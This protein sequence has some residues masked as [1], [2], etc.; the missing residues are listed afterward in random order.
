MP[1]PMAPHWLTGSFDGCQ[2]ITKTEHEFVPEK[3][4]EPWSNLT[5]ELSPQ[6]D[7][8][9]YAYPVMRASIENSL[10]KAVITN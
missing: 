7:N 6:N 3:G 8:L 1:F 4:Y 10:D 5:S 9:F 2:V